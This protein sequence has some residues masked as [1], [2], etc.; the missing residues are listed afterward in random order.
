MF[1][2]FLSQKYH[3]DLTQL[4]PLNQT[5]VLFHAMIVINLNGTISIHWTEKEQTIRNP[6]GNHILSSINF[7]LLKTQKVKKF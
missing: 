3:G 1:S 6:I 2:V 5:G 7:I 4:E